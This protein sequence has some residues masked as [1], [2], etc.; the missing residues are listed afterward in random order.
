MGRE[1]SAWTKDRGTRRSDEKSLD[2]SSAK[3]Q[4]S[5]TARPGAPGVDE[6]TKEQVAKRWKEF[7]LE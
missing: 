3:S 6:K 1:K 7:G 2:W 5:N 4:V